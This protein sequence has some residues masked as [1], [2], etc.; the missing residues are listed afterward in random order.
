MKT[1]TPLAT[2]IDKLEA[3]HNLNPDFGNREF[4]DLRIM[5]TELLPKEKEVIESVSIAMV[6]ICITKMEKQ[7][8]C[9][10]MEAE[11]N[12]HFETNYTQEQ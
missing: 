3:Y 5:L 8:Y 12:N 4:D 7:D 1:K 11:F 6:N 2:A 10:G 9:N